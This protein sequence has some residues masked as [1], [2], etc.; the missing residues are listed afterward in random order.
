MSDASK[1]AA[2]LDLLIPGDD[3]FPAPSAIEL[4]GAML[5]HERFGAFAR[6]A[7]ARLPADFERLDRKA[8]RAAVEALERDHAG[9][10]DA[11][12]TGLYSLYY[13]HPAVL[14]AVEAV[15]GY[16]ARPPQPEGYRLAPFDPAIVAVPA[17]RGRQYREAG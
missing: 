12:I 11:L 2:L 16:A 6:A 7:L 17:A 1:L 9:A 13:V 4:A 5:A 14:V 8:A 15:S 10:F 3:A